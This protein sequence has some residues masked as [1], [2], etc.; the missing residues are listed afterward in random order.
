MV[1]STGG[2][3]PSPTRVTIFGRDYDLTSDESP[4]YAKRIAAYVDA[5]MGEIATEVNQSDP[6]KLAILAAM[7]ISDLLIR[8]RERLETE[9]ERA[10]EALER[11]GRAVDEGA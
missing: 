5:K 2:G 3:E 9:H 6:T 1:Q 8:E 10:S 11:L 7:E 4:E